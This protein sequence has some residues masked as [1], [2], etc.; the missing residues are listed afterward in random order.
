LEDIPRAFISYKRRAVV[1]RALL[2][3]QASAC[4]ALIFR[5]QKSAQA[6]ACA[7]KNRFT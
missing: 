4:A 3:A 6:E 7:T 2:V 1:V 5:M